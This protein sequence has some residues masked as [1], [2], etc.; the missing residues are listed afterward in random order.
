[1]L[2]LITSTI[3][4][5]AAVKKNSY[6]QQIDR[7]PPMTSLGGLTH[8]TAGNASLVEASATLPHSL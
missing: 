8:A 4:Q 6:T 3:L 7:F 5:K 2:P 1:M